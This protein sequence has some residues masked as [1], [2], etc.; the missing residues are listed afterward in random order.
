MAEQAGGSRRDIERRLIE[1]SFRDEAFRQQLLREPK[2]AVEQELGTQ[3]PEGIQV[4]V[5]QETAEPLYLVL[6]SASS[7]VSPQS[8]EISDE[9]LEAVAGG[10]DREPPWL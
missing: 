7:P 8:G 10:G 4:R 6:P 5:V 3:L 1:K 9:D 2:S